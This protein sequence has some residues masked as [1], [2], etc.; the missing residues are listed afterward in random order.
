VDNKT[1]TA[2]HALS[3][4]SFA[5]AAR[6]LQREDYLSAAQNG[7]RFLLSRL[8]DGDNLF[9]SYNNGYA[10]IDAFLEDY[11]ASALA[12]LSLYQA[13]FNPEWLHHA[14]ILL[15]RMLNCFSIRSKDSF[16]TRANRQTC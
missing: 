3:L 16:D 10:Q 12:F 1:I 8:S 9:R 11:A 13:D 15:D 4:C 6:Y 5:E 7:A 14:Q 2:W